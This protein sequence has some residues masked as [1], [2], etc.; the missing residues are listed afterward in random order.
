M[1]DT[2]DDPGSHF[3]LCPS[4]GWFADYADPNSFGLPLFHSSGIGSANYAL[5]GATPELLRKNGYE[6]TEVPTVDPQ[7]EACALEQVG[8]TR[9]DCWAEFDR[10]LMEETAA[11][12]PWIQDQDVRIAGPRLVTYPSD[13]MM[14]LIALDQA[15][16]VGGGAAA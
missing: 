10:Y 12:I 6:V 15:A 14:G 4:V 5:L 13:P 11:I 2:C 7:I 9:A 16:L 3:G 8:E 1:Y